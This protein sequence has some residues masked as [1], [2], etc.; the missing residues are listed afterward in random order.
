MG[1][2]SGEALDARELLGTKCWFEVSLTH[3]S[4]GSLA[5]SGGALGCPSRWRR[6][7]PPSLSD[8]EPDSRLGH[9]ECTLELEL[10]L[11]LV[12]R[13]T[14]FRLGATGGTPEWPTPWSPS[15]ST[16][17]W[18]EGCS[19][20]GSSG[21]VS[22]SRA[23]VARCN[24][25]RNSQRVSKAASCSPIRRESSATSASRRRMVS[26]SASSSRWFMSMKRVFTC[27]WRVNSLRQ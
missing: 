12:L 21:S 27:L 7:T 24:S 15:S 9:D 5:P 11:R 23:G 1:S 17:T 26:C 19:S 14:A 8:E 2:R 16:A 20:H 13:T 18:R 22:L 10:L 4:P 25:A 3:E 6:S